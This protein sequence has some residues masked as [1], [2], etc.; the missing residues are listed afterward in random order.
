MVSVQMAKNLERMLARRKLWPACMVF[1]WQSERRSAID[2]GLVEVVH[3]ENGADL[4]CASNK[5]RLTEAGKR[6]VGF[7]RAGKRAA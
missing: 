2:D 5:I 6:A 4:Y 3:R 1:P 7:F